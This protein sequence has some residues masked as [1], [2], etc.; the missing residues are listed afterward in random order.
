[1][2]CLSFS[3]STE[4]EDLTLNRTCSLLFMKDFG[5]RNVHN[6]TK[7]KNLYEIHFT[8]GLLDERN[9]FP[10]F[11]QSRF[12]GNN[13]KDSLNSR[14]TFP[15][16]SICCLLGNISHWNKKKKEKKNGRRNFASRKFISSGAIGC[17][18]PDNVWNSLISIVHAF[19]SNQQPK[20]TICFNL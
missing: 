4:H 17:G 18:W 1:M 15:F 10:K 13:D 8:N 11:R 14:H 7:R 3:I 12:Q 2:F 5:D 16:I 9:G 6:S 19:V 20:W